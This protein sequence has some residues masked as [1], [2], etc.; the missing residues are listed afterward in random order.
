MQL[1]KKMVL[2]MAVLG[3]CQLLCLPVMMMMR[4]NGIKYT[5]PYSLINHRGSHEIELS[6]VISLLAA[7]KPS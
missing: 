5:M 4:V 2:S 7:I 1:F 3:F 6:L